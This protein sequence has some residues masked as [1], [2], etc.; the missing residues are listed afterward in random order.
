MKL[1]THKKDTLVYGMSRLIQD[2]TLLTPTVSLFKYICMPTG[3]KTVPKVEFLCSSAQELRQRGGPQAGASV[4]RRAWANGQQK[5]A[6][7]PPPRQLSLLDK[8]RPKRGQ[9]HIH[10]HRY[11]G[12]RT[13]LQGKVVFATHL[14]VTRP[15][16]LLLSL[17]YRQ[18]FLSPNA[19]CVPGDN[20]KCPEE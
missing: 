5:P 18:G 14:S 20:A 11:S 12:L 4:L 6:N 13:P 7:G 2:K 19:P 1:C 9:T 16:L 3:D 17:A 15:S 8:L 10:T